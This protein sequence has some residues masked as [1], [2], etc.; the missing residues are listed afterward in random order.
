M[1]R[2]IRILIALALLVCS[3]ATTAEAGEYRV[4]SCKLP[5]GR[6]AAADGWAPAGNAPYAW[7]DDGCH[8]GGALRAGLAG[9]T[10]AANT[11]HIGWGFDS[12]PAE[13]DGY[14]IVR[15]GRIY[16]HVPGASTLLYSSDVKNAAGGGYS[17]DYCAA[18]TGCTALSGRL[19]RAGA[20]IPSGSR[21]WFLM[22][23]CGGTAGA[24]C[25]PAPGAGEFGSIRIDSAVFTLRDDE[26]PSTEAVSGSLTA[27]GATAGELDFVATDQ[28]SGIHRAAIEIDGVETVRSYPNTSG[29]RC[30]TVGLAGSVND[31]THRRPCPARQQ[32]ELSL[33]RTALTSGLHTIRARVYDAA[34]NGITV[35]GPRVVSVATTGAL[36]EPG[37]ARLTPDSRSVISAHGKAVR[38]TGTLRSVAG[39]PLAN[40]PVEATLS[41]TATAVGT[42]HMHAITDAAG[43]YE[44]DL[45]A[46]SS[47]AVSLRHTASGA[48]AGQRLIV[49]ARLRLRARSTRV[50]PLGRMR[51]SGS[52]PTERTRRGASV[53][54]KVRS[55]RTWRTVGVV[56]ATTRGGFKFS[57]RFRRTRHAT[58]RFRAV[59]LKSSDLAVSPRASEP[60]RVRVG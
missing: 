39:S 28:V 31:F 60:I 48:T 29:G 7:F 47:R 16:G 9:E 27:P 38:L 24:V 3:A 54:I 33:A 50:P 17:V 55:G 46:A 20:Q 2:S 30:V 22:V 40:Q 56:R 5:D 12:G 42:R 1:N 8:S 26:Q 44:F 15:S 53:A 18:F 36:A 59:A 14:G 41:S 43:R 11:S 13:I 49:R 37:G 57:Y 58:L 51:L 21:A 35:F 6:P 23:G 19:D 4:Y 32:V 45:K 10:Q 25:V 52:I 34:G